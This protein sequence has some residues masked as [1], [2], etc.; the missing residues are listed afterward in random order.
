MTFRVDAGASSAEHVA[1]QFLRYIEELMTTALSAG[2]SPVTALSV[3]EHFTSA[4]SSRQTELSSKV[5]ETVC[6]LY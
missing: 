3:I 2:S 1:H 6:V 5:I 4:L